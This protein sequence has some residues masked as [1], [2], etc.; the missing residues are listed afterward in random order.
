MVKIKANIYFDEDLELKTSEA[1]LKIKKFIA[2]QE[3]IQYLQRESRSHGGTYSNI[4]VDC[5]FDVYINIDDPVTY[6]KNKLEEEF[7][8]LPDVEVHKIMVEMT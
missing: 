4:R 3:G 2:E 8:S 6:V 1:E 5:M 7:M